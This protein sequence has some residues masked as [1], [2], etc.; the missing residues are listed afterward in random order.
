MDIQTQS[1]VT[2]KIA[3]PVS[4]QTTLQ[5]QT[6]EAPAQEDTVIISD[7]KGNDQGVDEAKGT[8]WTKAG[9][10]ALA[11]TGIAAG[12]ALAYTAAWAAFQGTFWVNA[13]LFKHMVPQGCPDPQIAANYY[14]QA[15]SRGLQVAPYAGA[16]AGGII[17]GLAMKEGEE[18]KMMQEHPGVTV[19]GRFKAA[20]HNFQD[21]M[22][23]TG[24]SLKKGVRGVRDA[25]SFGQAISAGGGAGYQVGETLGKVGG[26]VEGAFQGS[27]LLSIL[28]GA[29]WAYPSISVPF[30]VLGGL[31]MGLALAQVG[32]L[33]GG[34]AGA[35][36]GGTASGVVYGARKLFHAIAG[37]NQEIKK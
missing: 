15:V 10:V 3:Q 12:A 4:L 35:V 21:T 31:G 32:S 24:D 23:E 36:V 33:A 9:K 28:T 20:L 8:F 30:S 2:T 29:P 19:K 18:S 37:K 17:T 13:A 6:P 16:L 5:S 7:A 25:A 1:P 14:L 27:A 22:R 26:F 34:L 11:G